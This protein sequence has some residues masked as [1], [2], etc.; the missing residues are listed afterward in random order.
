MESGHPWIGFTELPLFNPLARFMPSL[1]DYKAEIFAI[2]GWFVWNRRNAIHFNR[3]VRP[4]DSICSEAGSLLQEFLQAREVELSPTLPQAIQRWRPP[5]PNIYKINFDAAVFRASKLARV[6]V[7]VRDNRGDP[8]RALTM[9]VP[10]RQSVAELEMVACQR[11][12]QFALEIGLT[13][14]VVKGDSIIVIEALK[15]G[16]GQF[17]SYEN[18]LDDIQFQST[19]FQFIDFSFT[20]RVCNSVADALAKKARFGVGLLVWLEDLP[21]DIA[22]LVVRDVH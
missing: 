7:I 9:H 22:P 21:E 1:D 5:D 12:V 11:A 19:C 3:A 15:N 10:F 6:G 2:A 8:I 4:V 17:A 16:I 18:I 13:Q 14:V 20:S